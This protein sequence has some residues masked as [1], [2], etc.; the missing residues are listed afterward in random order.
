MPTTVNIP[1][2]FSRQVKYL[3]RKYPSAVAEVRSFVAQLQ[4][5]ERPGDEVPDVGYAGV[6][7]QRLRN[8]TAKRGKQGGFRLIYYVSQTDEIFL[9]L[10]YSKTEV[11][12]I[13]AQ[14]IRNLLDKIITSKDE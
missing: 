12:G 3:Q 7:K 5:G 10:I 1:P 14:E 13:S 8:R 9:L 4:V 11:K 2:E 6:Y